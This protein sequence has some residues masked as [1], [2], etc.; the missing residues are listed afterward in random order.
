MTPDIPDYRTRRTAEYSARDFLVKCGFTVIRVAQ[1]HTHES[2]GINLVAW[3][4]KGAILFIYARSSRRG[5][6]KEDIIALSNL[7]E[8]CQFPGSVQY[9]IRDKAE[10]IRYQINTGGALPI[11]VQ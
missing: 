7:K 5:S 2:A 9:W 8:N 1:S 10:W 4:K 6:L 11:Q 3:D